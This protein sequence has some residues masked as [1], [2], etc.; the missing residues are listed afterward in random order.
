MFLLRLAVNYFDYATSTTANR[1]YAESHYLPLYN[2]KSYRR[3]EPNHSRLFTSF[4]H[5]L[6]ILIIYNL[7]QYFPLTK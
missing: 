2:R 1:I 7:S 5:I 6:V 4:K 3:R